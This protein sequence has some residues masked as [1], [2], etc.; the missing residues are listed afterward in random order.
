MSKGRGWFWLRRDDDE[1][2]IYPDANRPKL[3]EDTSFY[4]KQWY[5]DCW[6]ENKGVSFCLEGF[7][8]VFGR[9]P[10]EGRMYKVHIFGGVGDLIEDCGPLPEYLDYVYSETD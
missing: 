9:V 5:S 10:K 4:G 1:V 6:G 7:R 8:K 2:F 3:Q